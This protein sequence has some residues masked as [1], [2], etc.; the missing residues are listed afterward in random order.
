MQLFFLGCWVD[1]CSF[2]A[3][4][5]IFENMSYDDWKVPL[6]C[7]I[8]GSWN[9]HHLLPKGLDFFILYSSVSSGIGSSAAVNYA[10]GCAFQDALVHYRNALGERAPAFNLGLMVEDGVL[11]SNETVRN[12]FLN[13][14]YLFGVTQKDM[15]ALLEY[16]CNPTLGIPGTPLQ[17]QVLVGIEVPQTLVAR[18]TDLPVMMERPL[19]SGTWNIPSADSPDTNSPRDEDNDIDLLHQLT[20]IETVAEAAVLV[21]TYLMHRLSKVL[22]VPLKNLDISK[23]M[24]GYGLDSLVAV[25]LRNWFQAKLGADV[26][27]FELLGNKTFGN[28]G[29]LVAGKSKVVA[30]TLAGK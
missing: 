19:F 2:A 25:E 14:G 12:A 29:G 3:Q 22:G 30:K 13:R 28:V 10:S 24:N 4:S 8:A 18:G 15:L 27:V 21:A 7:K 26:A 5:K 17:S 6:G 20:D 16:H 1:I 11:S 23:P 9:L